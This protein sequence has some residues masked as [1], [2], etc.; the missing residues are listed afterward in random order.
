MDCPLGVQWDLTPE[1]IGDD[2]GEQNRLF[3]TRAYANLQRARRTVARRFNQG[4][5]PHSYQVGDTVRNH[6]IQNSDKANNTS[7]KLMMRWTMPLVIS[8]IV[9]P[10]VVF[11][12]NPAHGGCGETGPC[13]TAKTMHRV[14]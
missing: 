12:A 2:T 13:N 14:M 11:L 7:A 5:K 6:F 1:I 3:W 8:K 10:N 4:R 9:K